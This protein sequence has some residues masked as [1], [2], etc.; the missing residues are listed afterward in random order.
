[1]S[2]N[3]RA[4][5]IVALTQSQVSRLLGIPETIRLTGIEYSPARQSLVMVL[6]GEGLPLVDEGLMPTA[7]EVDVLGILFPKEVQGA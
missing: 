5:A 1:M 3:K 2:R 6:E 7:I 4:A